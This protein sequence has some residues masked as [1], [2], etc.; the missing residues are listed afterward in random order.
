V[1]RKAGN[2]KAL[3]RLLLDKKKSHG[4]EPEGGEIG[5]GQGNAWWP[6]KRRPAWNTIWVRVG[7][8]PKKPIGWLKKTLGKRGVRCFFLETSPTGQGSIRSRAPYGT[9]LGDDQRKKHSWG[10]EAGGGPW[11]KP[12]SG[13]NAP[14]N[15]DGGSETKILGKGAKKKSQKPRKVSGGR[16]EIEQNPERQTG[17]KRF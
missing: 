5:R 15:F 2:F 6:K 14:G 17:E 1:G 11:G 4:P 13:K 8:A 16:F 3:E 7:G 9:S 12:T 10:H